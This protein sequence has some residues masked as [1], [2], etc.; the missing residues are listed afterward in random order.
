MTVATFA[1]P[2]PFQEFQYPNAIA[3]KRAIADF[4]GMLLGKLSG[5][6]MEQVHAIVNAMLDKRKLLEQAHQYFRQ[7]TGECQVAE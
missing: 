5:D 4:L 1:D 7:D 2:E 3:V 6:Q